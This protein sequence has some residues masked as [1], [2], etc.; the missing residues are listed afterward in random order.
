[1]RKDPAIQEVRRRMDRNQRARLSGLLA[2]FVQ[3]RGPIDPQMMEEVRQE[4]LKP[5]KKNT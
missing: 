1:M 4:W 3:E 5:E 2:E